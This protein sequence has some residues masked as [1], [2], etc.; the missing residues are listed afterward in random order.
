MFNV[1]FYLSL[2]ICEFIFQYNYYQ[3]FVELHNETD[4]KNAL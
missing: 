4:H 3:I 2:K 1:K